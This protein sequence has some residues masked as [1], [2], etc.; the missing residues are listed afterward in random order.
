MPGVYL[1]GSAIYTYMP[2]TCL[3]CQRRPHPHRV[4]LT[5]SSG[6]HDHLPA[7]LVPHTHESCVYSLSA[8]VLVY[9]AYQHPPDV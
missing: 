9:T 6:V 2:D 5:H 7:V 4:F 8:E 1:L 3:V